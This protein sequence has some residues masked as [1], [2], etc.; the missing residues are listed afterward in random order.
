MCHQTV[1]PILQRQNQAS[2][3]APAVPPQRDDGP[4]LAA[5]NRD[6]NPHTGS[7]QDMQ[8]DDVPPGSTEQQLEEREDDGAEDEDQPA[9]GLR[10][11][12]NGDFVGFISPATSCSSDPSSTHGLSG[13]HSP[14]EENGRD[15]PL[16]LA[17]NTV[18]ETTDIEDTFTD[19]GKP[20]PWSRLSPPE[21]SGAVRSLSVSLAESE[22][23]SEHPGCTD[24][25]Q[26]RHGNGARLD[27]ELDRD[28]LGVV[29][30]LAQAQAT[31]ESASVP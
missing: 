2:D 11:S 19:D 16:P 29:G 30:S 12:S 28:R 13:T 14:G 8:S 15:S 26:R 10:F 9:P 21:P 5:Q 24:D 20:E 23:N 3:E 31:V 18:N 22:E 1:G 6:V 25:C 17:P 7:G 27:L 4:E